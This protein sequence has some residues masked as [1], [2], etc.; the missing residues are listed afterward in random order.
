[1]T[2]MCC[3]SI[4]DLCNINALKICVVGFLIGAIIDA[5]IFVAS[6]FA[7]NRFCVWRG[8]NMLER[9]SYDGF[10]GDLLNGVPRL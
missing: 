6:K 5:I 3:H 10:D 1:M 9:M 4:N 8:N 2:L 7:T